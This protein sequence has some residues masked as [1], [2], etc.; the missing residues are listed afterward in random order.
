M[1][2]L[3]NHIHMDTVLSGAPENSPVMQWRTTN[4]IEIPEVIGS[5]KRTVTGKL[6]WHVS[7][8]E[9]G[10]HR[11]TTMRYS[12][13]LVDD[14]FMT[15]EQ[16]KTLLLDLHGQ[17]VYLVDHWH[18]SDGEDHTNYV[19]PFLLVSVGEIVPIGPALPFYTVDIE[20]MSASLITN[21]HP[22]V[23]WILEDTDYGAIGSTA[24]LG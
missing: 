2:A 24:R 8:D 6:V 5:V 16:Q 7:G 18:V 13:K 17:F 1:E 19:K 3:Q 14:G 20:L 23:G 21:N 22:K 9:N 15:L 12:I 10:V 4:R 11:T